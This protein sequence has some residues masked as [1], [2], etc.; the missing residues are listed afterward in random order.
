MCI[1]SAIY[2]Q[3]STTRL[4]KLKQELEVLNTQRGVISKKFKEQREFLMKT[5]VPCSEFSK[6]PEIRKIRKEIESFPQKKI[7]SNMRFILLNWPTYCNQKE[8][9][10]SIIRY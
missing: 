5:G 6:D 8:P 2:A 4:A 10:I 7:L 9:V 1:S 3:D